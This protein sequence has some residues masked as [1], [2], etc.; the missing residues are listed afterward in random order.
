MSLTTI[1][2]FFGISFRLCGLLCLMT[3]SMAL[4][5]QEVPEPAPEHEV[6][7]KMVGTWEMDIEFWPIGPN[8]PSMKSTAKETNRMLGAFFV[9]SDFSGD[10]GGIPFQGHAQ[11]GYDSQKK[12]FFGTWCDIMNPNMSMMT[13]TYDADSKT[14]TME[15]ESVD[16][17]TGAKTMGKNVDRFL[18]DETREFEMYGIPP[19]GGTEMVKM[20]VGKAKRVSKKVEKVQETQ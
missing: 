13:G 14:M 15:Y 10:L 20:M 19:G 9:L 2:R 12:V 3:P 5:A 8:G 11:T 4:F 6:L 17:T 1:S 18:D 7:K 16:P